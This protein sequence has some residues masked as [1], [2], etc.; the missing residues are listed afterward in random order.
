[1]QVVDAARDQQTSLRQA[2]A[3]PHFLIA[4]CHD[5]TELMAALKKR[6]KTYPKA[7]IAMKRYNEEKKMR[8]QLHQQRYGQRLTNHLFFVIESLY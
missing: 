4:P 5:T 2:S 6:K 7:E 1:V 8:Q 3:I